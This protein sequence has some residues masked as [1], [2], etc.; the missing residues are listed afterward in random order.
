[1]NGFGR[2]SDGRL[3]DRP[4][5]MPPARSTAPRLAASMIPGPPPEQTTNRWPWLSDLAHCV[6]SA[7]SSAASS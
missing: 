4:T 5:V 1:M 3:I 7:A 6:M 2:S